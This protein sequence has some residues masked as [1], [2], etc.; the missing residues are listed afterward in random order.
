MKACY[1]ESKDILKIKDIDMPEMNDDEVLLKVKSVGICGS[2]VHYWKHGRIGKFVVEKPMILGHELSAEI[3]RIGRNVEGFS[4]GELVVLE[5]GST[6]GRC[7]YCREG[8]YNL[9]PDM[10][11][12]ATPPYDG[13]LREYISCDPLYLFKVPEGISPGEATLVEPL[14]V[15]VHAVRKSK[16]SVGENVIV[17]GAGMIGISCMLAAKAAGAASVTIADINRFRLKTA[18]MIGADKVINIKENREKLKL[19]YYDKAFECSGASESLFNASEHVR[20]G[21]DIVLIGLGAE[22]S[23]K[24]PIVDFTVNEQNL[25]S[26]FRYAHDYPIALELINKNRDIRKLITHNFNFMESEKAFNASLKNDAMKVVIN[27]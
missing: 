26:V 16:L 21:G 9:C 7:R 25:I 10:A 3:F 27:F 2:D 6:C 19:S 24:I 14:S 15:G 12:F 17:Y 4:E 23:Q 22:S 5:P 11:F 18:E 8:R 1:L 20:P 13:A